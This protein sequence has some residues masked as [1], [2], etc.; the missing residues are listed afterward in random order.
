[1]H[2]ADQ[3]VC[4]GINVYKNTW[5]YPDGTVKLIEATAQDPERDLVNWAPAG[6]VG[7]TSR[8]CD[9]INLSWLKKNSP[10]PLLH[11]IYDQ[12]HSLLT[13]YCKSYYLDYSINENCFSDEP[14]SIVR[15]KPGDHYPNHYDSNTSLGR[16]ISAILYLNDDF[17]GGELYFKNF[18]LT[19]KPEAGMLLLFP[20]NYAYQHEALPVTKGNKYAIITWLHDRPPRKK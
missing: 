5:V 12:Y 16:H 17:K 18:G 10:N 11:H 14:Y 1:M 3:K 13:E 7:D 19:I 8:K 2:S 20:S 9:S 4:G 6:F 15:Y